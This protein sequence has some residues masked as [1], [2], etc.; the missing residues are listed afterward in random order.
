MS[1]RTFYALLLLGAAIFISG[2]LSA[3]WNYTQDDV[4]ITYVFSRNIAQGNGF[5][6]NVAER[7]QGSTTPLWALWMAGVHV[8]VP[9]TSI[10]QAGNILGGFFLW[11]TS[12]LLLHLTENH[13][14]R[15]GQVA[16][17]LLVL[18]SPLVYV[19][20]GMETLLYTA[21][22][23]LGLWCWSREQRIFAL[24]VAGLLTWTRADGLVLGGVFGLLAIAD[25]LRGKQ[26]FPKL[27]QQGLAYA[28]TIAPWFLFAWAYFGTPLPQTFSAKQAS[29]QGWLW[30]TDGLQ[31]WQT[32]YGSYNPLAMVVVLLLPIGM[33]V[34]WREARLRAVVLW[35]LCYFIGY[36]ILNVT[37][38]WYYTPLVVVCIVIAMFGGATL[39]QWLRQRLP[40]P[41][42]VGIIA[43]MVGGVTSAGIVRSLDFR[44]APPRMNTYRLV[45]EWLNA[46]TP[47]DARVVVGDL[48]IVGYW[49]QRYTLDSPGLIVPTMYVREPFYAVLKFQ[50]DY[51]V[52]TQAFWWR[53]VMEA[54]WFKRDYVS[55][56]Q[57][58]T[59][60][61]AEFSPMV[62]YRRRFPL[63]TPTTLY[64]GEPFPITCPLEFAANSPLPL[65]SHITINGT[66]FTQ[67]FLQGVYPAPNAVNIET[68]LERLI[69]PALPV[70]EHDWN[71]TCGSGTV[72]VQPFEQAPDYTAQASAWDF[73]ALT[74]LRVTTN[75]TRWSGGA[76]ALT[77][78]FVAQQPPN[79]DY[80]LSI[81]VLA[82]DGTLAAQY[83]GVP[84]VPTSQWTSGTPYLEQRELTLAPDAVAGTYSVY[85]IWYDAATQTRLMLTEAAADAALLTTLEVQFPGGSG[86]P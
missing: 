27:V 17:L 63:T 5:V 67:P 6:F 12:W 41:A 55:V 31:R 35:A 48:G 26:T 13:L 23:A 80:T 64:A 74:G 19:S 57:I 68:L 81:Q 50:P 56:A 62:I 69:V 21:L 25:T 29:F 47:A 49:A 20:L 70:G 54:D 9:P 11:L 16:L 14:D 44:D 60:Q 1:K 53:A 42:V 71:G 22:L 24:M 40:L 7:V 33:L 77:L 3:F 76:V 2:M 79:A 36:T 66:A 86:R 52:T 51:V 59:P 32:F 61:D 45:G 30:W 18:S 4:F 34:L 82:P 85:A 43:V 38:F 78:Q 65:E 58:S 15:W 75:E 83:D 73:A 46:H 72:T 37:N 10:L 39:T 84:Q 8:L 28:L